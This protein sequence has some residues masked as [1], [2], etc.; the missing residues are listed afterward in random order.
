MA[1]N[2]LLL[3]YS[4]SIKNNSIVGDTS[5]MLVTILA[6]I[7]NLRDEFDI[8]DMKVKDAEKKPVK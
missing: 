7:T 1:K 5:N 3:E 8:L 6:E 2:T 4:K